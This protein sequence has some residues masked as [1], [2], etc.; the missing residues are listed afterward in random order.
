MRK[1]FR[2]SAFYREYKKFTG[3]DPDPLMLEE[4]ETGSKKCRAMPR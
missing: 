4:M 2:N 1:A 3:E